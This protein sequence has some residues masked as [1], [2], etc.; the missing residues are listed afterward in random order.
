MP[1]GDNPI[2]IAGAGIAGLTTA[3][4]FSNRGYDVQIFERS[5]QFEEFGAGIQISPNASRILLRLGVLDRLMS[6]AAE[7]G[8]VRLVDAR[9]DKQLGA[10]PLGSWAQMR[11]KAPYLVVHRADLHTVLLDA[12]Q[13]KNNVT[14]DLGAAATNF[15][16]IDGSPALVANNIPSRPGMLA[17]AADGVWSNLRAS[18]RQEHS[19][20]YSGSIAWRTLIGADMAQRVLGETSFGCVTTYLSPSLHLVA[21]P[22]RGGRLVN[23]V[24]VMKS[25][26]IARRWMIE[27]DVLV[28]QTALENAGLGAIADVA[29]D[30]TAWPLHEVDWKDVWSV[31]DGLAMVGDAAHAMT[32]FAA[33]G[34]AMAIEDADELARCVDSSSDD[35]PAALQRYEHKRKPRVRRV[36]A[37]GRFNHFT[38]HA[39]GPV[40]T[41][42]N[43][44]LRARSGANLMRDFDWLYG[45]DPDPDNSL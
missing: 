2:L 8:S 19:S 44:V 5:Y 10:M 3:L 45:H 26:E 9:S 40:A 36:V 20:R 24:A 32:P 23:L 25:D 31:S 1:A 14:I 13:E 42:R 17:V 30:W 29:T 11:W 6:V 27:A 15:T 12:V 38:W 33:Q 39:S 35:I 22:V 41:V 28:L 18:V 34:A 21:Y 43:L 4:A 16:S 37:R 7:P